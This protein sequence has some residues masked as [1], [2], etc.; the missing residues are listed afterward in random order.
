MAAQTTTEDYIFPDGVAFEVSTDDG[1]S[2]YDL[3]V[4]AAG[5]VVTYNYDKVET[6]SGNKGK[7]CSRAKNETIALAPSALWSWNLQNISK[8]SGGLF[9]YTA[10]A[11]TPVAG[12]TQ[13]E[14]SG[15]W[16]YNQ[17]ILIEN[18]NADASAITVNSVTGGT[19]GLLV[20]D[21]DYYVG[22]NA[23]GEY[24]VFVIDS[25][26][27]TTEAQ[28]MTI[29]YDYTPATGKTI[30]AGTSSVVLS[31]VWCR[32][33]HYTDTALTTYD[34]ECKVYGCDLDA[35]IGFNLKGANEDGVDEVTL[36]M[37][38]NVDTSLT[39]GAQLLELFVANS[40]LTSC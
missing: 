29:D 39:D 23:K 38:G 9:N 33:R 12:A 34:I 10:V 19:D 11:G 30:T 18:Q 27:V 22:Q 21:T 40:A 25:A 15:D 31:R 24:G 1:S 16:S 8:L 26:T 13:V 2:W 37:T 32:L 6:G 17:F 3:G 20:V 5:A 4:L 28:T 7:L 35:G 36:S 14:A